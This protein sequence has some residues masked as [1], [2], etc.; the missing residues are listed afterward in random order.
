MNLPLHG[1]GV[2]DLSDHRA[3]LGS[4]MLADLGADVTMVEPPGGNSIRHLA[5]F[6]DDEPSPDG[7][8]QHLYFNVNKRS[9]VL[10]WRADDGME[11]LIGLA[12]SADI[13][14]ET[15]QPGDFP[16]AEVRAANPHLI[17]VSATPYGQRGPKSGWRATDLTATAAGGLLQVS[18]ERDDPPV[19][20][21][22]FPGHTMT[23]LTIASS[24]MTALHGRDRTPGQPGC[25][26]DISMQ[27]AT[28]LQVV[29]TSNPNIWRWRGEAPYRPALSQVIRCADDR[30]MACNISP[31]KLPEFIAMLD[32]AGVEHELDPD[33]WEVIH[34]GDRAAWQYLENPLQDLA[35][36]LAA[37]WPRQKLLERLWATGMPAMPTLRFS[38]FAESE[39]YPSSGQFIGVETPAVGKTLSYSRSPLDPVQSPL[40]MRPAPSL[41]EHANSALP[42]LAGGDADSPPLARTGGRGGSAPFPE[43]P[44]DGIRV[45]DLTWVAAGPLT[46]R[47]M[48]NFGADVIKVESSGERMDPVRV[49]PIKGEFHFDLPDLY[50]EANTGKKSVTIDLADER[51]KDL[52]RGL[53]AHCDVLVNNYSAG[54]L[55][56]MGF[57]WEDLRRINPRLISLHLPGVGGDSP[58]RPLRT[59]GNL[60]KAAAGMNFQMGY[61]HQPPRGMGVAYPDFTS[62]HVGVTAIL[63]ALRAREETG[64]GRE[65]ELSQLS[66][67]V[68]LLG[69]Q[70]MRF[71]QLGE[72]LPRPG[73]RDPNMCPHGVFPS[74]G[75]DQ[76]VAI[77]LESDSQWPVFARTIGR[78]DWAERTELQTLSGRQAC[79]DE[80]E[81][82]IAEWSA[83]RSK[84]DAAEQLQAAGIAANAVEDLRDMMDIDEHFRDH[85]QRVEQ[86]S[87][88]GFGIWIDGAPWEFAH[89]EPRTLERSPMLGEHN[90]EVL[91][92]LLGKSEDEIAE[93]V[94]A[95]VV[96]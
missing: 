48:A 50:N 66:A 55:A 67:T 10:D 91:S 88:P 22:A 69:A 58:W 1:V 65:I 75:D 76:W 19:H 95:G 23:G 57:P 63:A 14:I 38:E 27:E 87:H 82:A 89:L 54:S 80:I 40:P 9:L 81:A 84:W 44:L 96:G 4:R 45:V 52:L 62:P 77:A 64:E 13:L 60:L 28:S 61:P 2:L 68:A 79:E 37:V 59:L 51:G 85:Y 11:R 72:D 47:L 93:L 7:S 5:P 36:D 16:V 31:N 83:Q 25:Q 33:N 74:E 94:A 34:R 26:I 30:W 56:R 12:E 21:A 86:P 15:N 78:S 32:E 35:K 71:D 8:Y 70:W 6:V 39:H 29:Q 53:V 41:D 73:N 20:G 90:E 24:A 18:G 3:A 42:P 92:G 17:V 49:Q 43:L 46:T